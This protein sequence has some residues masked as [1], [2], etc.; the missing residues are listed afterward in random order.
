MSRLDRWSRRKLG[1]D[2]APAPEREPVEAFDKEA[3]DKG[4]FDKER[5]HE[6]P[7]EAPHE[8]PAASGSLDHT[9]PDP[10]ALSAEADFSAYLQQGVSQQLHRRA[11]RRLWSTGDYGI[12]D[13]LDDYDE[14]YREILKPLS[15]DIAERLRRWTRPDEAATTPEPPAEGDEALADAA[16]SH[17]AQHEREDATGEAGSKETAPQETTAENRLDETPVGGDNKLS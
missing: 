16:R 8:E 11:L 3:L 13:G 4:P 9:L 17:E 14:N 6:E 15:R 7:V 1:E 12:R 10:D 2:I 5:I